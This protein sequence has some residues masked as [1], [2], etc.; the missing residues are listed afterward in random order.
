MR[1]TSLRRHD[2]NSG[3]FM[4]QEKSF[5]NV[6]GKAQVGQTPMRLNTDVINDGGLSRSSAEASVM[7][8]ERRAGVIQTSLI[9][10]TSTGRRN[11]LDESKVIPISRQMIM[12]AYHKVRKKG[13]SSGV[14]K[15]SLKDFDKKKSLNLYKIWNRLSS[16]SYYPPPVL[17]V[18]IPKDDGKNRQETPTGHSHCK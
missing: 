6:K 11:R 9:L 14:D 7:E 13:G 12:D 10:S 18:E 1:Q 8:V 17:E 5:I 3:L 15:E 2:F 16:G 4:E